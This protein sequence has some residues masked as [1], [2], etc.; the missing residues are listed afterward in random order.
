MTVSQPFLLCNPR[1]AVPLGPRNEYPHMQTFSRA[2]FMRKEF[3]RL[4]FVARALSPALVIAK[5]D[6]KTCVTFDTETIF[7]SRAAS[8]LLARKD[9]SRKLFAAAGLRVAEGRAF[10][11]NQKR[12]A[13]EFLLRIQPAV[14]KPVD[15]QKGRGVSVGIT[16]E[17]F[18]EAWDAA[19]AVARHGILLEKQESGQEARYLVI[20]GTCVA[21]CGRLPPAVIGDGVSTVQQLIDQQNSSRRLNPNL[22]DRPI[23][24]DAHRTR[25]L[26]SQGF[27]LNSVPHIHQRVIIDFKAGIS[28]G[29][30]SQNLTE[31]VHPSMKAVAEVVAKNIP[32]LDVA[33]VDIICQDHSLPAEANGYIIIE[34]NTKPGMG[35]HM[36]PVYGEPINVC[37]YIAESCARKM[38]FDVP[39]VSLHDSEIRD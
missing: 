18:G 31:S 34:A 22:V 13:A 6:N 2:G 29:G 24:I 3:Q 1:L 14:V 26:L 36:F 17:N 30:D 12:E 35:A 28:S 16:I 9:L 27:E 33:G 38:G 32:G 15:G 4:G 7:T 37:R 10:K 23:K 21:V 39:S 8:R 19:S 5:R 11:K 20:D 25:I